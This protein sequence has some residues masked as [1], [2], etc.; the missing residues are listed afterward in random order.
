MGRWAV[1]DPACRW[2]A[3][4]VGLGVGHDWMPPVQ[5]SERVDARAM[6]AAYVRS[7][8]LGRPRRRLS[9]H[10]DESLTLRMLGIATHT[11]DAVTGHVDQQA[12]VGR[13]AIHRAHGPK[14]PHRRLL[15]FPQRHAQ[16]L[17]RCVRAVSL[18]SSIIDCAS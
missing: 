13:V 3:S 1:R 17:P 4:C 10:A 2:G 15:L 8:A 14:G 18:S 9:A 5:Q 16:S 12:A 7:A 11:H 6:G